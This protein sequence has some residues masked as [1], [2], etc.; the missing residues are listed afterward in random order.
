MKIG[1]LIKHIGGK[2]YK[3]FEIKYVPPEPIDWS[4]IKN[5]DGYLKKAY[6][7]LT[8]PKYSCT[9]YALFT[10]IIRYEKKDRWAQYDSFDENQESL[11][12]TALVYTA[13]MLDHGKS[14]SEIPDALGLR[15][16]TVVEI[17][18]FFNMLDELQLPEND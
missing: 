15:P 13:D 11:C 14:I 7:L 8:N 2:T 5:Q 16:A 9:K 18:K 12:N 1:K 10:N 4:T 17:T 6:C 3:F